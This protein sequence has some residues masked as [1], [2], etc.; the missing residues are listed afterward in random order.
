MKKAKTGK[1]SRRGK[2]ASRPRGG[3]V[4]REAGRDPV[5]SDA[6]RLRRKLVLGGDLFGTQSFS[7]LEDAPH[8]STGWHGLNPRP[9]ARREIL[10]L[11]KRPEEMRKV[12]ETFRPVPADL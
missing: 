1:K 6:L 2:K 3:V 5:L 8:V 4:F 10:A 11:H 7:I 9:S 12:L